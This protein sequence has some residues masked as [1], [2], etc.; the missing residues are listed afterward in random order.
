MTGLFTAV[1]SGFIVAGFA[2]WVHRLE[3]RRSGWI[4]A[5]LPLSLTI[6]FVSFVE[7]LAHG[8]TFRTALNWIPHLGI[9]LTFLL[10]GLSL[11]FCLLITGIG[12]IVVIYSGGYLEGHPEL[13]RFHA[14]ILMFMA[15][16]LG[17]VLSDNAIALFVFW[18][19]T[20]LSSF[21]LIGFDHEREAS[22]V[23]ALQ[24]LL[25]TG[26]GGLALMAGLLLMG[27]IYGTLELT[28]MMAQGGGPLQSSPLFLPILL[29]V[30]A[31]AFTKSA[32]F[33]FH[34]W[35]PNAM[36]AP[37][38]VSTYLHAATMVKAGVYLMARVN[39]LFLG[40]GAWFWM[41]VGAGALTMLLGAWLAMVQSD[42]KRILAYSTVS[43]LG[44]LTFL[45]GLG[46]VRAA[47]A[48]MAYLL[49]HGLYKG[50]LFL[51]AGA[52]DHGTGTRDVNELGGLRNAMPI[53]ALAAGLAALSMAGIPPFFG[54]VGKEAIYAAALESSAAQGLVTAS[55]LVANLLFVAI[56]LIVGIRPFLGPLK[57]TPHH[58]HEGSVELWVGPLL[59]GFLGLVAGL[60]PGAVGHD[61]VLQAASAVVGRPVETHLSLWHGWNTAVAL[62]LITFA[63]GLTVFVVRRPLGR[64]MGGAA[65]ALAPIGPARGYFHVLDGTLGLARAATSVLQ[66]GYLNRYLLF[67]LFSTVGL[68]GYTLFFRAPFAWPEAVLDVRFYEAGLVGVMLVAA[69]AAVHSRNR[70]ATV[71]ALGVV[72]YGVGLIFLF[73]GAP[74]LAMTQILVETLTVIL[75]VLVFYR[76]PHFEILTRPAGTRGLDALAALAS[77]VLMTALILTAVEIQ[78]QPSIA[79]YFSEN[80]LSLAKGRNIVNVILVDF[81]GFDTM[82]EIT[83]LSVAAIGV[84]GLLKLRARKGGAS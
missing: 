4:L 46:T 67:V 28:G 1:L 62:S 26:L 27:Q 12:T 66:S 40:T 13:G 75:F 61:F 77:G 31:G 10:D 53:T 54:F 81:R 39:P 2:P 16:M 60:T 72:G 63:A 45:L 43:A 5:L 70:L 24:A 64:V 17:V 55:C 21:F 84:Y 47:E 23:A 52:V 59:L 11:L 76:M 18:E 65:Q 73:F 74:D 14:Y 6:Y 3:P 71:I 35:L 57:E 25:V 37:A 15:S 80:S 49:V 51:T 33:P 42:L 68:A 41:L 20:S 48:A 82:G 56:G 22:R 38:P 29:L 32:Q 9:N 50:A 69:L 36:E 78:W 83:V 58:P 8:E 34:I 30:L 79:S 44:T 7:P 19:L